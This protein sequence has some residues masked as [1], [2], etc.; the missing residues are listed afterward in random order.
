MDV[1]VFVFVLSVRCSLLNQPENFQI[2]VFKHIE[3]TKAAGSV[4]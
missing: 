4:V 1:F 2:E 3:H